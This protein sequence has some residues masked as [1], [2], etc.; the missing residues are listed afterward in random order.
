MRLT[1]FIALIAL[2]VA[3]PLGMTY[4]AEVYWNPERQESGTIS[5]K[6]FEVKVGPSKSTK[7]LGDLEVY[8]N[9]GEEPDEQAPAPAVSRV[10]PSTTRRPA[11]RSV[12]TPRSLR[13]APAASQRSTGPSAKAKQ[14][15]E[16]KAS[17]VPAEVGDRPETKKLQWGK[18]DVKSA[19]PKAKFKWGTN[20]N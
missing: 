10:V 16:P 18:V 3:S 20:N 9:Y 17:A 12:D 1:F 11:A 14:K 5:D 13:R 15:Q 6:D 2:L 4:A 7:S 19:G 8:D